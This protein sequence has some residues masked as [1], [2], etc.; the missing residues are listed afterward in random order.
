MHNIM[1]PLFNGM[2]GSEFYR[3]QIFPDLF[4]HQKQMMLENWSKQDLE[5]YVKGVA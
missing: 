3:A 2:G 4:P 5:M 1:D